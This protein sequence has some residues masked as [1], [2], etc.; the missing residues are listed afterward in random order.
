[1]DAKKQSYIRNPECLYYADLKLINNISFSER[2]IDLIA[3][4]LSNKSSKKIAAYLP[5]SDKTVT[6]HLRNIMLKLGVNSREEIIKL[7]EKSDKFEL[8]KKHYS[9]L[10]I[11]IAFENELKQLVP[12][13]KN[14]IHCLLLYYQ[15]QRFKEPV[16]NKISK[17]LTLAGI[18]VTC[19]MWE[20]NKPSARLYVPKDPSVDFVLYD[21]TPEF[22]TQLQLTNQDLN[23]E[24][25]NKEI[26]LWLE[27]VTYTESKGSHTLPNSI[28]INFLE[29]DNFYIAILK[30]LQKLVPTKTI[31]KNIAYFRVSDPTLLDD[32]VNDVV[33]KVNKTNEE[34]IF[35]TNTYVIN[36]K[37][38][39]KWIALYL[40]IIIIFGTTTY[41]WYLPHK[42]TIF[43]LITAQSSNQPFKTWP[44][45]LPS[46]ESKRFIERKINKVNFMEL[47]HKYLTPKGQKAAALVIYGL[48]GIG[49]TQ[50]AS[51]YIHSKFAQS[52]YKLRVWFRAENKTILDQS[53]LEFA[54]NL[55]LITAKDYDSPFEYIR[56]L[57][58]NW[59]AEHP[60]WL[61]I[62]DNVVDYESISSYLPKKGGSI[63]ITSRQAIWPN[64]INTLNIKPMQEDEAIKLV[65]AFSGH[66][67]GD[68]LTLA[69]KLDYLPLAIAQAAS[70][71]Q[72]YGKTAEEYIA[73]YNRCQ[74]ELLA[75]D[76]RVYGIEHEPVVVTWNNSLNAMKRSA[77]KNAVNLLARDF[78]L[79]SAYLSPEK[80]SKNIITAWVKQVEPNKDPEL[81]TDE[82]I[83]QLLSHSLI[84]K[85]RNG[86]S[87]NMHR[88]LQTTIRNQNKCMATEQMHLVNILE[89]LAQLFTKD[90]RDV[91]SFQDKYSL[92]PHV[93]TILEY[94]KN[95]STEPH[96]KL[97]IARLLSVKAYFYTQTGMTVMQNA[98]ALTSL[99]KQ[100][101]EEIA[102]ITN[103]ET[104]LWLTGNETLEKR[105]KKCANLLYKKLSSA[106]L[107]AED[108]KLLPILY[109]ANL[110]I[111]GRMHF[112]HHK[113]EHPEQLLADL[114]LSKHI[115]KLI[116][117][118]TG[119]KIFYK[120]LSARDGIL[121]FNNFN[122][123]DE[124]NLINTISSYKEL[125]TD[126]GTYINED[127]QKQQLGS[128]NYHK[129]VCYRR[130]LQIY[131]QL[132]KN[133]PNNVYYNEALSYI[134]E[135]N[136]LIATKADLERIANHYNTIGNFYL[137]S[138]KHHEAIT[139]YEKARNV[140]EAKNNGHGKIDY[141][142]ADAYYGLTKAYSNIKVYSKA[143][144]NIEKCLKLREIL[145]QPED[146]L[147][148]ETKKTIA[149]IT[150]KLERPNK[151][152]S[153]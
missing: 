138:G 151:N 117:A 114:Y 34:K 128:D 145:Y 97:Q 18:K 139:Y 122:T 66:Q 50:L 21:M 55:G 106:N 136:K 2:E 103:A 65:H 89:T 61:I 32:P 82:I 31:E 120:I 30:L 57:V 16:I 134:K 37:R 11:R 13:T 5:I 79:M 94:T 74:Q 133:N 41:Q 119:Q 142:L 104:K 101:Y 99:A 26:F 56:N 113:E 83:A 135:T 98:H 105:T 141:P 14:E 45:Q 60:N 131:I 107:A 7:I 92:L 70:Y 42:K 148:I 86:T 3:C 152:V 115:S 153:P 87:F 9:H 59:F 73:L 81:V 108:Q 8:V 102:G 10:L 110:Y 51:H 140:E 77:T 93:D 85:E 111:A 49:K 52:H 121:C 96:I 95:Y 46:Y 126:A 72:L 33:E 24:V 84:N 4:L 27:P 48:G 78:L 91:K 90:A 38:T 39:T 58:L 88:L 146:P 17:Y 43:S 63:L 67:S 19:K 130:L 29:E 109:A 147:L 23:I 132:M 125:V 71:M 69:K 47:F 40:L 54:K 68:D 6:A 35:N 149:S 75:K 62:F 28:H 116:E 80:I 123:T 25:A 137:V 64:I 143:M 118:H 1:M 20:K 144:V 44:L 127:Q 124:Q 129:L 53:Y 22:L 112:F 100:Y 150:S 36:K 76:L 12:I 15:R